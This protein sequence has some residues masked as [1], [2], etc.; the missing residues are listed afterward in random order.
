M[1][2]LGSKGL[3]LLGVGPASMYLPVGVLAEVW[4][5]RRYLALLDGLRRTARSPKPS[6]KSAAL[7]P[8]KLDVDADPVTGR[9]PSIVVV[10][11]VTGTVDVVAATEDVVAGT[12][13]VVAGTDDVAAETF[14]SLELLHTTEAPAS[15]TK[16]TDRSAVPSVSVT[17]HVNAPAT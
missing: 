2:S 1:R 5:A 16:V 9:M 10:G 4:A 12:D 8:S 13:D 17:L 14:W 7:T 3:S 11:V 15:A 6:A